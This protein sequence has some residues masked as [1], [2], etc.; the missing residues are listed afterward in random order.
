MCGPWWSVFLLKIQDLSDFGKIISENSLFNS[1]A[2]MIQQIFI[3]TPFFL[4]FQ[5]LYSY[6]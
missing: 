4:D 2:G 5:K 3:L 1:L 6:F